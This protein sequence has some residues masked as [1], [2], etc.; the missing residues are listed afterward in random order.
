MMDM[1]LLICISRKKKRLKKDNIT[2]YCYFAKFF[3]FSGKCFTCYCVYASV[4]D[5]CSCSYVNYDLHFTYE[6]FG[7]LNT[8]KPDACSIYTSS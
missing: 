3:H 6:S 1:L 5:F 7:R 2:N 8:S 4:P